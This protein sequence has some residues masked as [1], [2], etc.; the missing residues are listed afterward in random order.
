[1][2]LEQIFT[3][4]YQSSSWGSKE[5]RS[6]PSA[7]L[8]RTTELREQ[9]PQL[10]QTLGITSL[11]DAGCGDWTWMR[12]VNLSDI[13]YIGADIV[14]PLIE[15]LQNTFTTST[16]KFQK[17]NIMEEPP[18]TADLWLVRDMANL[19]SFSEIQT[20]IEKFLESESRFLAI[21]SVED[22]ENSDGITPSWRPIDFMKAPFHLPT[23][24][25]QLDDGQQWF[26]KKSL[27]VYSSGALEEWKETMLAKS[28]A[29]LE[30]TLH[31]KQDRNAHLTS[32]VSLR[33]V[34]L[35]GHKVLGKY[36]PV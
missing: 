31:D 18:E 10:F 20:L 19:Y 33:S 34:E 28:E 32:N 23:P 5:S 26:R 15:T 30:N 27:F 6:G 1:M 3:E 4:I 8:E 17:M 11:F 35:R 2:N 16:V 22:S 13:T 7:T 25:V 24:I 9:L 36:S 12:E 29:A 14:T 21:T